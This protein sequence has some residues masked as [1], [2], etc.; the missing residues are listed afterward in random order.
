MHVHTQLMTG[1]IF[2]KKLTDKQKHYQLDKAY[3][4]YNL[5]LAANRLDTDEDSSMDW[6]TWL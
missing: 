3:F 6:K 4:T 2:I 1:I 5:K